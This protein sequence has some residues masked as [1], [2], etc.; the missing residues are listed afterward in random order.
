M[1][2]SPHP[3]DLAALAPEASRL[4]MRCLPIELERRLLAPDG[5]APED[6]AAIG[7]HLAALRDALTAAVPRW[8][9]GS[10]QRREPPLAYREATLVFADVTGYTA[11][12]ERLS[13]LGKAG[14]EQITLVLNHFFDVI[15]GVALAHGGDLLAFGGDAALVCFSGPDHRRQALRAAR[16]MQAA[17]PDV[18]TLRIAGKPLTLAVKIGIATGPTL[19]CG[20]GTPDRRIALALGGAIEACDRLAAEAQP[21]EIRLEQAEAPA[22]GD[23]PRASERPPGAF[24]LP[25]SAPALPAPEAG[26]AAPLPA[27]VSPPPSVPD[28]LGQIAALA[29]Y[30]PSDIFASLASD[31]VAR[32]GEGERREVISL[33]IHLDGLHALADRLGPRDLDRAAAAIGAVV[34]AALTVIERHGGALAHADIYQGGLK[35]LAFFGAPVAREGDAL[36]AAQAALLLREQLVGGPTPV[37]VRMGLD[38]GPVVAGLLGMPARWEY[39]VIGS[40]TNVAAR[41]MGAGDLGRAE[42]L[43]GP[44][45]A[46]QLG[47]QACGEPRPLR[48]KGLTH[49]VTAL[50][51]E[52]MGAASLAA[53]GRQAPLFGREHELGRLYAAVDAIERGNP[54]LVFLQGEAGVGKSRLA[55]EAAE[56]LGG[57]VTCLTTRVVGVAPP[58]FAIFHALLG[59][60]ADMLQI[61]GGA[62]A[63]RAHALARALCPEQ[64]HEIGPAIGVIMGL[65]DAT[66]ADLGDGPVAQ[67]RTLARAV[68]ALLLAAASRRPLLWICED[69]HGAD[70]A[71]IDLIE[72]LIGLGGMS[73]LL[74]CTML[75]PQG[76][77]DD[78]GRSVRRV[79]ETAGRSY[80]D[81]FELIT[82]E[83]L[84]GAAGVDLVESLVP[85]ITAEARDAILAHTGGNP[86][87]A[88]LLIQALR[89]RGDLYAGPAGVMLRGDLDRL[90]I[91]RTLRELVTSQ[92]DRLP[93]EVRRIGQ[94]A[95]VIASADQVVPRWLLERVADASPMALSARL[96]ELEQAHFLER[97]GAEPAF[98]FRHALF[99]QVP[100][101]RLLERRRIELHRRA[102][103]A[104]HL[105]GGERDRHL[106]ALAHHC[107]EGRDWPLALDYQLAF[108]R[109]SADVYANHAARRAL[110]RA[111]GLARRLG[112]PDAAAAAREGLGGLNALLGRY[113]LARRQIALALA[114]QGG[115]PIAAAR[116]YRLLAMVAE[117]VGD[118]EGAAAHCRS[119][120]AALTAGDRAGDGQQRALEAGAA[121]PWDGRRTTADDLQHAPEAD[122]VSPMQPPAGGRRAAPGVP[123]ELARLYA[124]LAEVLMRRGDLAGAEAQ[125]RAGLAA[126]FDD[127][128]TRERVTL[129]QRLATLDG[130]RGR[131]NEAIVALE[132]SL[133]H[134]RRLSDPGL[135]AT[136]LHNLGNYLQSVGRH[137]EAVPIY[138][139]SLQL[140]AQIGDIDGRIKTINSLGVLNLAQGDSA[141]ALRRYDEVLRLSLRYTLPASQALATL[142]IGRLHYEEGRLDAARDSLEAARRTYGQLSDAEGLALSLYMI[143][144]V[145]LA[146]G[147]PAEAQACAEQALALADQVGSDV[148]ASCARRVLGEALLAGGQLAE[149]L[150]ELDRAWALQEAIG[151]PFDTALILAARARLARAQGD[152]PAA[153]AHL[154][155]ALGLAR[156]QQVAYLIADLERMEAELERR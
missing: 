103:Q 40:A 152:R 84:T 106:A 82:I 56:R 43:L 116:R 55:S 109:R 72:Q 131:Y 113:T 147:R 105:L 89:Q 94:A 156:E 59:R 12:T 5:L 154:A 88:E 117:R 135:T 81:A 127:G 141:A 97:T 18:N 110:L 75:R 51:L 126:L 66:A 6:G 14:Q 42:I 123:R 20:V 107:Y 62:P 92:I 122:P 73:R 27:D 102:G 118:Y 36:R 146:Q 23:G 91:P 61:S 85:Q 98:R 15:V 78:A 124:Q 80:G 26:A 67:Q 32:P 128:P 38:A 140:K 50:A 149:A 17:M 119:G 11:L 108:G 104:L 151:D 39:T 44:N 111:L 52:H 71:S 112:R 114:E 16:A 130:Q 79:V 34:G 150:A 83:G 132:Q 30:L 63:E 13:A 37:R 143:G 31:P 87:F 65:P 100:Y 64:I 58:S 125:C 35:L 95:A 134:A 144:D 99:Q 48:L 54:R 3:I 90:R 136:V 86:L 53:T 142:N 45:V 46:Q 47:A 76:G 120:V 155:A 24:S 121:P 129:L 19:L 60:M 115:D 21:D 10:L 9:A 25:P 96:A 133:G 1:E 29:P 70:A 139:E 2:G 77:R 153:R 49:P 7:A 69:L 68:R 4:L 137:A 41:L 57:R 28:L 8:L 33:F 93:P 148:Y 74:L 138:T 101:D 145:A 22:P